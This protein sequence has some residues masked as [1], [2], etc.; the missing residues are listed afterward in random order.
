MLFNLFEGLGDL[1]KCSPNL[2]PPCWCS[3]GVA[4][5]LAIVDDDV[6]MSIR[7]KHVQSLLRRRVQFI[8]HPWDGTSSTNLYMYNTYID[9]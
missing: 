3:S 2:F 4:V 1:S 6:L 8:S 7:A 9:L 5:D